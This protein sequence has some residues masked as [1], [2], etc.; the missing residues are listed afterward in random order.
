M[1]HIC[2]ITSIQPESLCHLD[3][4]PASLLSKLLQSPPNPNADVLG[5]KMPSWLVDSA[6]QTGYEQHQVSGC[7]VRGLP[8]RSLRTAARLRT[9]V[10]GLC[11]TTLARCFIT[12]NPWHEKGKQLEQPTTTEEA[13]SA[14]GLDWRVKLLPIQT[15][16]ALPREITSRME[17][18]RDDLKPGDPKS[19]LGLVYPVNSHPAPLGRQTKE[20]KQP[21]SAEWE[22]I[23]LGH[24][25]TFPN[26]LLGFRT[27]ATHNRVRSPGK[28]L[29]SAD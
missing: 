18:M 20:S 24:W 6:R 10:R 29:F 3:L 7:L 2:Q 15:D 25:K 26:P 8:G 22:C 12:A 5:H 13:I 1:L 11:P 16:E 21:L 28:R 4:C 9:A 23:S 27:R 19:V 17:V 14:S